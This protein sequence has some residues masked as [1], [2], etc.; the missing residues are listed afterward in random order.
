LS[1]QARSGGSAAPR[2]PQE[3]RRRDLRIPNETSHLASIREAV[4][5][6]VAEAGFP[7]EELN[8]LT[9]AVDEAVTNVMEY[10]Y[11][12][13]LEGELFV[14]ICI[15][16]SDSV[17]TASIRDRGKVFD[18]T[19]LPSPDLKA[20]L[21]HGRKHGL[22]VFLMRQIMDEISYSTDPEGVNELR[23]VRQVRRPSD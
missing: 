9:L 3:V 10:A 23:L 16:A 6:V 21:M 18:P 8:R 5:E 17:F 15:E 22:G 1:E 7:E 12:D 14:E 20:H 13:D 19:Q 2:A 11:E 4:R